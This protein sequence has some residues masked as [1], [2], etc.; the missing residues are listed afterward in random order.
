MSGDQH[1]LACDPIEIIRA[2]NLFRQPGGVTE[3]RAIDATTRNYNRPRTISGYFDDPDKVVAALPMIT[4]ASAIYFTPNEINPALLA[5]ACNR[6]KDAG[7]GAATADHDV[8]RR[9]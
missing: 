2:L 7:K 5:R 8:L 6:L 3:I 4:S 9:R 1:C